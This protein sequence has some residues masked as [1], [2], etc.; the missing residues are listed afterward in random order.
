MEN[1]S[2]ISQIISLVW[3]EVYY[4]SKWDNFYPKY[5]EAKQ[6]RYLIPYKIPFYLT[7]A[8]LPLIAHHDVMDILQINPAQHVLIQQS[9]DHTNVS[10]SV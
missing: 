9:N 4:V 8:T 5:K 1:D 2:F 6:L 7:S 10:L 3:D